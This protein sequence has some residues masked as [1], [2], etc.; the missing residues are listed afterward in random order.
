MEQFFGASITSW[1]KNAVQTIRQT[2]GVTDKQA[3]N[4]QISY[5][6]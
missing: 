6:S 4:R 5:E 2:N 1:A 3:N